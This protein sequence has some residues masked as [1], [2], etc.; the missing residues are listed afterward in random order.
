VSLPGVRRTAVLLLLGSSPVMPGG[1]VAQ[2]WS[3]DAYAGQASYAIAPATVDSRNGVLGLRFNQD[4]RFLQVAGG[5]PLSDTDVAWGVLGLGDRLAFRRGGLEAGVDA[6]LVAHGQRDPVSEV[7]GQGLLA[8]FLP[9][10]SRNAGSA[11][12]EIRSGLRWYGA[13]LGEADWTRAFWTSELRGTTDPAPDLR[14]E[15]GLRHYLGGERET[16]TQ[17]GLSATTIL[18]PAIVQG[19]LGHW[20]N[21]PGDA[22]PEWGVVAG[23][24]LGGRGQLFASV[25]HESFD[26][27]YL[28]PPRSSWGVGVSLRVGRPPEPVP[29]AGPEV[30]PGG[31]V[32]LRIPLRDSPSPPLVAGDFTGWEPLPM[33]RHGTEW[34]F[35]VRL[36]P[37]AYRYAFRSADGEWFVPESV[38][39]RM[40][41]GMG[42]W[43]AVLVVP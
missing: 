6:F 15:A 31:G 13:R 20:V 4:R 39:N 17:A 27:H 11:V 43:V 38:P 2:A 21:P 33:E 30:R 12:L 8:E 36:S 32:V 18:G 7:T 40:D 42:G 35:R 23:I 10:V 28:T 26:P 14:L 29:A 22:D 19:S 24:P 5:V 9:V 37:G 1:V 25:R 3:V 34:R 41:D 16:Y